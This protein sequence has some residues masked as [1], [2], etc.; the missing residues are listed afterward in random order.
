MD[1]SGY[2]PLAIVACYT[3]V[4]PYGVPLPELIEA[5]QQL[6]SDELEVD[7]ICETVKV[8]EKWEMVCSIYNIL[9]YSNSI[10]MN[11]HF[12]SIHLIFVN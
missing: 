10:I 1:E 6:A 9:N 8:I 4:S 7:P 3:N 5:I 2:V 12:Y 11:I